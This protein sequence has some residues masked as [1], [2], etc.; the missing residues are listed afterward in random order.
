MSIQSLNT[1]AALAR[2]GAVAPDPGRRIRHPDCLREVSTSR[3]RFGAGPH[4]PRH[5]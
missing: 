2:V 4:R 3:C 1:Q 5:R